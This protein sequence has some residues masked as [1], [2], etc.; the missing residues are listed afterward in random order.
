[1]EIHVFA[2]T[3]FIVFSICIIFETLRR[4]SVLNA[5]PRECFDST[6]EF[7]RH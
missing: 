5:T 4:D 1:M 6:L 7:A 3:K 2:Q